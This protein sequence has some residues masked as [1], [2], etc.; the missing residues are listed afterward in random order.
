MN[1]F[2]KLFGSENQEP[3]I[4]ITVTSSIDDGR[5][6]K[7]AKFSDNDPE[8]I[9][10]LT[11]SEAGRPDEK[12]PFSTTCPYC[13]VVYDK[14]IKRKKKCPDCGNTIYVRTTQDL[15]PSSALTEGEV[16]HAEFYMTMKNTIFITMGDFKKMEKVLQKK[17]NTQKVNTYDVLW[18][19]YNSLELYQRHVDKTYGKKQVLNEVFYRKK[20]LD[21]AAAS[22]QANRGH[23][24]MPY[25]QSAHRNTIQQSKMDEYTK[26]LTVK[27][28][29]CC[30]ACMKFDD[31]TFSIDF[32][33][34]TPVLP[35]KACTRPFKDGSKFTFCTCNYQ[36]YY[37]WGE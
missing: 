12:L 13:G 19:L 16:N 7:K 15:Y 26:G 21:T 4:K 29:N 25:L 2:S 34:K 37:E 3:E 28:Y 33:E 22:Y 11:S 20:W 31:K 9:K 18:G 35:V 30:E 5:Q 27:C 24:P 1:F 8:I 6:H 17:W 32:L 14:P 36:S 10:E 23:D